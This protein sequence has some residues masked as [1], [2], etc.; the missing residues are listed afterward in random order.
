VATGAGCGG[1]HGIGSVDDESAAAGFARA[2]SGGSTDSAGSRTPAVEEEEEG[3][4]DGRYGGGAR[5]SAA[6]SLYS[7]DSVPLGRQLSE[8]IYSPKMWRGVAAV[9]A[10][11]ATAASSVAT[12]VPETSAPPPPPALSLRIQPTLSQ[13]MAQF[14]VGG[15]ASHTLA[16][17]HSRSS[18]EEEEE[19][20]L[21]AGGSCRPT[22]DN[23]RRG[24]S[25]SHG[26][27]R[28]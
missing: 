3:D 1:G 21:A 15:V 4:D 11:A 16:I 18:E 27:H 28:P 20:L 19:E 2:L 14:R 8:D 10:T 5:P 22:G 26:L 9:A 25:S 13:R 12:A 6:S 17:S 23:G 24:C 7:M